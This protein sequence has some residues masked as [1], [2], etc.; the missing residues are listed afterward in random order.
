MDSCSPEPLQGRHYTPI[1]FHR[2]EE[3]WGHAPRACF[4]C[5]PRKEP[6]SRENTAQRQTFSSA[7]PPAAAVEVARTQAGAQ[8]Q[9]LATRKAL[10]R[11]GAPESLALQA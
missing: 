8:G 2:L 10:C 3:A 11:H 9:V 4:V 1:A 5:R 7:L 6:G